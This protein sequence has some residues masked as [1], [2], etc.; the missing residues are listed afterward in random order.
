MHTHRERRL[1]ARLLRYGGRNIAVTSVSWQL[2]N[3]KASE[4][5]RAEEPTAPSRPG[6]GVH[7]PHAHDA[8]N[9]LDANGGSIAE[10]IL[11]H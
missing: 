7:R 1:C 9:R 11:E 10:K 2:S 4:I 6:D 3:D 8:L 5:I